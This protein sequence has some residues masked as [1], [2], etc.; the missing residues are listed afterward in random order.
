MHI[1]NV[2]MWSGLKNAPTKVKAL[3]IANVINDKKCDRLLNFKFNKLD[4]LN[5]IYV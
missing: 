5:F 1:K 3:R 4:N 2:K